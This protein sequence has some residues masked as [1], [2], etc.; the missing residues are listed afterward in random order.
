MKPQPFKTHPGPSRPWRRSRPARITRR[1]V[2]K[3]GLGSFEYASVAAASKLFRKAPKG[4]K[5]IE[6]VL[7][8]FRQIKSRTLI[9]KE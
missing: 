7:F 4:S 2:V 3:F 6:R 9:V 5:L 8:G 1:Y